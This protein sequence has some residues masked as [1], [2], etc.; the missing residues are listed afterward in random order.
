ML[1]ALGFA[2]HVEHPHRLVLT[3][4]QL[5]GLGREVLQEGWDL[6]NDS[7]RAPLC[8]R[9]RAG[10]V[11]CG[12]LFTAARRRGVPMPEA[13]PW[14]ELF[15]VGVEQLRDVCA[16][17]TQ[18]YALPRAE[19]VALG[20]DPTARGEAAA[21]AVPQQPVAA[22][23]AAA[24]AQQLAASPAAAAAPPLPAAAAAAPAPAEA[25]PAAAPQGPPDAGAAAATA[26][27]NGTVS[28]SGI[29][30][31]RTKIRLDDDCMIPLLTKP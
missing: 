6:A 1:R 22:P 12:V 27:P 23:P 7:L 11:A 20:E 9:H 30:P 26:P 19:Y 17:L 28:L 16:A 4:G 8:V 3:F 15:G 5:L 14:W 25:A 31:E 2:A 29:S 13:P 10:V 21:A 18:L 24:A